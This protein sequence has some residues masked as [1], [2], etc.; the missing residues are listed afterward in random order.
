[1]IEAVLAA[2]RAYLLGWNDGPAEGDIYRSGL[3]HA[4]LNGVVRLTGQDPAD[5]YPQAVDRLEGVPRV[6][7]VGEDSDPG[8]AEALRS[9]GARQLTRM[10]V[11]VAE[12]A[13]APVVPEP[14]GVVIEEARDITEFVTAYAKALGIPDEAVLRAAERE[15]TFGHTVLRLAARLPDGPIAGTAE[16]YLSDGLVTLYFVGTQPPFRRRGIGAALTQAVLRHAAVRGIPMAALTSTPV[17][18]PV[19]RR[20]GFT[21]VSQYELFTF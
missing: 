5:A 17:A 6:W 2:N 19:Y 21:E 14:S 18:L 15:K 16:A 4:P 8:T 10:P 1:M 3:P 13:A 9:L 20:L 7:W 12:V 11:M